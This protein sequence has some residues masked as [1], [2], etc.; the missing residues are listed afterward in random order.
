MFLQMKLRFYDCL[1]CGTPCKSTSPNAV[2]CPKCAKAWGMERTGAI[3]GA[4]IDAYV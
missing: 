1:D 2:R 3:N 4:A